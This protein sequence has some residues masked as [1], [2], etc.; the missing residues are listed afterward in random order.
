MHQPMKRLFLAAGV[1]EQAVTFPGV[2]LSIFVASK[3]ASFPKDIS[4]ITLSRFS[5]WKA[6]SKPSHYAYRRR[7]Q[8]NPPIHRNP[9]NCDSWLLTPGQNCER[10]SYSIRSIFF[11]PSADVHESV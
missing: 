1:L 3:A 2:G 8:S 11:P 9:P 4:L 6:G 5:P 7:N 10:L